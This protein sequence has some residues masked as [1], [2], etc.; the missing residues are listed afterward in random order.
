MGRLTRWTT[1]IAPSEAD[2]DA[3]PLDEVSAA[4][5]S[6][7][8]DL[9]AA[10]VQLD[11]LLGDLESASLA[12]RAWLASWRRE[13]A[14]HADLAAIDG[15]RLLSR[16][17]DVEGS[18]GRRA[19][20]RRLLIGSAFETHFDQWMATTRCAHAS[21]DVQA[22]WDGLIAAE[23]Q[24][25]GGLLRCG[26]SRV[27]DVGPATIRARDEQGISVTLLDHAPAGAIPVL[28]V[29]R[30]AYDWA[31][32]KLRNFGHWLLDSLPQV[33]TLRDVAPDADVLLPDPLAGFQ[34]RTLA[35][36]GVAPACMRPWQGGD[37]SAARV[38]ILENDGRA[39]GGRPY[40][41]VRAMRDLVAPHVAATPRRRRIYVSRRD[42]LPKRRWLTNE[43][44]VEAL[45]ARRG[46]EI[47]VIPECPLDEQVRLFGEAHIVAGISGA[48]LSDIVFSAPG[49]H[50]VVIH[51]DSLVRWYA[52]EEGA[53]S[54]W[55]S[56]E[57][58][59]RGALASLGDS[60]RF[61]AHLSAG[62]SQYC[63]AFLG[64]DEAPL[65][66]LAAF[67]DAVLLRAG[68]HA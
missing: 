62:L 12:N 21:S 7:D 3:T 23:A 19:R 31:Q 8:G 59:S 14:E 53:R 51:S 29:P 48:G 38:L 2:R 35:L 46:F 20:M 5:A 66:D 22:L 6:L 43:P 33:V 60:P 44:A 18:P 32:R 10:R 4:A 13:L 28:A 58:A 11:G 41:S 1:A 45:F 27:L 39:G 34:R 9:A 61:Y 37:L 68:D 16:A 56:G 64:P 57:R 40:A 24:A 30:C 15:P 55:A 49:T 26:A 67:L 54:G 50:V 17:I 42:A 47:L 36:V 65:D 52:D 63:H 25:S